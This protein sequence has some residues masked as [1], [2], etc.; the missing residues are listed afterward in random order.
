MATLVARLDTNGVSVRSRSTLAYRSLLLFSVLYFS[1]PEDFIPGLAVIPLEKILGGVALLA[2][3]GGFAAGNLRTKFPLELKLLLLLF[4]HL[5]LTIPFAY[6]RGGSFAVVT[7]RFS[8]DVIVGLLATLIVQSFIQLR[9]LVFVQAVAVGAMTML[10]VALHQGGT[11]MRGASSGI[12]GNPNDL[13]ITIAI[14]WP[15]CLA[16]LLAA[17]SRLAKLFWCAVLLTMLYGVVATYSRSGL[18]AL[19]L[20]VM[21]CLWEFG[22]KGKR[23]YLLGLAGLLGVVGLGVTLA[24]PGYMARLESILQ[25]GTAGSADRGSWEARRE[26]LESSVQLATHNPIFGVG[27]GNFPAVTGLW[28]VVHNTFTELGAEGGLPA[29]GLFVAIL[30]LAFRNLRRVRETEAYRD[31]PE[32]SLLTGALWASLAAYVV[33]AAF[34]STE[35]QLFPYFMV[36]YTSVLYRITQR[37]EALSASV[38]EMAKL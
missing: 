30:A 38:I 3:L 7:E 4:V 8:K 26:L 1:R 14:N 32:V 16:F 22:V 20:S 28:R 25:G 27:P 34:S 13:A 11:R 36:A 2:L 15:L 19:I 6:W 5:C 12:Y 29:L 10:S 33:G 31:G 37:Q 24:T 21:V 23:R 18:L 9:Q 17:R 35:Y